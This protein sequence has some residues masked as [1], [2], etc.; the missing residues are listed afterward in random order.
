MSLFISIA[1]SIMLFWGCDEHG[2]L[3]DSDTNTNTDDTDKGEAE[4]T[5]E[6]VRYVDPMAAEPGDGESWETAVF[7]AEEATQLLPSDRE[8]E[9]WVKGEL[10]LDGDLPNS[11]GANIIDGFS[12]SEVSRPKLANITPENN[13]V[14]NRY[15]VKRSKKQQSPSFSKTETRSSQDSSEG[16]I[17]SASDTNDYDKGVGEF[18]PANPRGDGIPTL[19]SLKISD[20]TGDTFLNYSNTGRNYL[21]MGPTGPKSTV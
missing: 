17:D 12:G 16:N 14:P 7:T 18:L 1:A 13:S 9:I 5:P 2:S 6:C 4:V 3:F 20:T 8:C 21:T 11:N 15:S 19:S 10:A